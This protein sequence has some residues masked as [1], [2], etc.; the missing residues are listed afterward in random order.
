ME[1]NVS[2]MSITNV[3]V[4]VKIFPLLLQHQEAIIRGNLAVIRIFP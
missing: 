4:A 1:L 3:F 2:N